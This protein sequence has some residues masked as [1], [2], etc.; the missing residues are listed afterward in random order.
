M[1]GIMV[2]ASAATTRRK[3]VVRDITTTSVPGLGPPPPPRTEERRLC[4]PLFPAI[5][6]NNCVYQQNVYNVYG[7]RYSVYESIM[8]APD[9]MSRGKRALVSDFEAACSLGIFLKTRSSTPSTAR[10][11][12]WTTTPSSRIYYSYYLAFIGLCGS[13]LLGVVGRPGR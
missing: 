6:V 3:A 8:H 1:L 13:S 4:E 10:S 5:I 12:R 9:V 11:T 7:C 2:P